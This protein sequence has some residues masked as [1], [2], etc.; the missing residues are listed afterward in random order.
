MLIRQDGTSDRLTLKGKKFQWEYCA[1]DK[2]KISLEYELD[3]GSTSLVLCRELVSSTCA[4]FLQLFFG[5]VVYLP[6]F[7]GICALRMW[8]YFTNASS[9]LDRPLQLKKI[10]PNEYAEDCQ[11]CKMLEKNRSG[12]LWQK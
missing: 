9:F 5:V 7:V 11:D 12:K 1:G 3:V 8:N 4:V 6:P 2:T 10:E